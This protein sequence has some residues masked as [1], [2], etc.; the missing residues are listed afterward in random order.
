MSFGGTIK[1][2]GESDYRRALKQIT[3]DLKTTSNALKS[4]ANDFNT[5]NKS[6][7]SAAEKQ[8]ALTKSINEQKTAIANAQRSY[9]QYTVALQAQQTRHNALNR[10]YKNAVLELDRIKKASGETSDEYKKQAEQVARLEGELVEST[11]EMDKSKKAMA[12]LKTEI[13]AATKTMDAAEKE[14]DELG[15]E[16]QETGE[17][18]EKAKEGFTVFKGVVSNLASQAIGAAI[19]GLKKLGGQL[20][21]VG[22]QAVASYAEYEQLVGGVETLFK[23]SAGIV[24]D[25]AANA[26]KTAQISANEYMQTVTSF[27]AS[28]LQGLNGDTAKA[29]KIADMAI[30]DMS[31]NANKMGTSMYMIQNAYQ[32]FAKQNFTMLDN[33]KLG[34]GGTAG[35]MARLI[36]ETGVMGDA[37]KATAKNVKEVPFDKMI[38]AIHKVQVEM[39]ITGTSALEASG[40]IEG[41]TKSMKAAWSNLLTA[42]ADDNADLSKSIDIFVNN[43]IGAA[44]N[45]VPK[46]K[47]VVESI[48]KMVKSIV[49]EVFPKLKREIPQLR[50][51]IETFEWFVKHKGAV[52]GALKA[53]VAAFAVS[54]ILSFT[55]G[56]SGTAKAFIDAAK[57]A[58]AATAATNLNTGAEAANTAGKVAATGATGALTVA[59]NLLNAAWKSNPIGLVVAGLAAL[60]GVIGVVIKKTNNLTAEEKA[61]QEAMKEQHEQLK[62]NK[63]AWADLTKEQQNAINVGMTEVSHLGTLWD[64]LQS[65]VDQ[66]GKVKKGYEER[67][68]FITSTLSEAL[69]VEI[70]NVDGVISKYDDLKKS[71]DDVMEKKKAQII[72][73]SQESLY[74]E[75]IQKQDEALQGLQTTQQ[76]YYDRKAELTN[77]ENELDKLKANNQNGYAAQAINNTYAQIEAKKKEVEE[78]ET[79]YKAQQDLFGEYAYNIGLYESNMAAFHAGKYDEMTTA[80][81]DYVKEYQGAE[82]AQKKMLEDRI[83]ITNEKLAQLE[84]L[85]KDSNSNIYDEQIKAAKKEKEQLESQLKQYNSTTDKEL[86]KT[87]ILWSD[88]LDEQLSKITGSKIEFREAGHGQVQAY[89]NGEKVGAPKAKEEMAKM[90]TDAIKEITKKDDDAKKAGEDLIDGVNKGIKNQDK[91]SGVFSSIANFGSTLLKKLKNSLKE[92][93]P[94]KATAEMGEY[95][96]DGLMIGVSKKQSATLKQAAGVGKGVLGA[97]S[98][99]L[100][101][102]VNIGKIGVAAN[103]PRISTSKAEIEQTQANKFVDMVAAFKTALSQMKI[104]LDDEVAGEFVERTVA[105]AVYQ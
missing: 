56:L 4:Q 97:L 13:N 104:E 86:N 84:Q 48:K 29:A 58:A 37:F 28:L 103:Y 55:K 68:S 89:I 32:G 24:K 25:Y 18:A 91:Q 83:T 85:K 87:E 60:V 49:T 73:D 17:Q 41:S 6:I 46:I 62:A 96:L 98:G 66:N 57:G 7:T 75:A 26:Y 1:L 23:D 54:K 81:W 93:S 5:N 20:V 51:L 14:V 50:P 34:Y 33:L 92:K 78:A 3:A 11:D 8:K 38:E 59:T 30:I 100:S 88:S 71:I 21:N 99:E 10:E 80:T 47:N 74:A 79:D 105:R 70:S 53:M 61:Q 15:K 52:V 31:D 16:T 22:K 69:G 12:A 2:T 27:S 64:E 77:L 72:L 39:G 42:I 65:I 45:T 102:G 43:A 82:E 67:A 35:E 94:S 44:K 40:T 90:T 63:E 76:A 9:N 101:K 19:S 36:N 95:L